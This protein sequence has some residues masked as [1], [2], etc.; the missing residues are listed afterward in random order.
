MLGSKAVNA[1]DQKTFDVMKNLGMRVSE[2]R[3]KRDRYRHKRVVLFLDSNIYKMNKQQPSFL[4]VTKS[5][6]I[7]INLGQVPFMLFTKIAQTWAIQRDSVNTAI[8]QSYS[9]HR[10]P[11]RRLMRK[12]KGKKKVS[13]SGTDSNELD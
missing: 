7:V 13:T 10:K 1:E 4:K 5:L 12:E 6:Y 2:I 9:T 8:I 3:T 11:S